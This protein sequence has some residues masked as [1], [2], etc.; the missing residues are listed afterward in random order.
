MTDSVVKT[1]VSVLK[2]QGL[3]EQMSQD[4]LVLLH[5]K[6]AVPRGIN[7]MYDL[8]K[9]REEGREI[10]SFWE[11]EKLAEAI[12]VIG[13][14]QDRKAALRLLHTAIVRQQ[15]DMRESFAYELFCECIRLPMARKRYGKPL[16]L[17]T[18]HAAIDVVSCPNLIISGGRRGVFDDTSMGPWAETAYKLAEG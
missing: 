3:D 5:K 16:P 10:C 1:L 14:F 6:D 11:P 15:E 7:S 8:D 17:S 18:L 4:I 13:L 2:E 9:R 12:S